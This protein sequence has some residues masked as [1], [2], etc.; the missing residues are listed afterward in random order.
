M[1]KFLLEVPEVI[2]PPVETK[3]YDEGWLSMFHVEAPNVNGDANIC[4][5]IKKVRRINEGTPEEYKE[6]SGSE[7]NINIDNFFQ[8]ATPEELQVM[9]ML[10]TI[11]KARAGI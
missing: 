7:I 5:R 4:A 10:L 8:T 3:I 2:V 6:E 1:T 11:I 9:A